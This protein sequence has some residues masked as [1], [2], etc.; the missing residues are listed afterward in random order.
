MAKVNL[1][2]VIAPKTIYE[3]HEAGLSDLRYDNARSIIRYV[4]VDILGW[5]DCTDKPVYISHLDKAVRGYKR[6]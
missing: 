5:K 4:M 6:P 1:A 2:E 3:A